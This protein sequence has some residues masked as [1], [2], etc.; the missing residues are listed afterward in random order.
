MSKSR[1]GFS[2]LLLVAFLAFIS[3]GLPDAVLGVAWPSIQGTFDR[4]RADLGYILFA[5]GAGYF[6][7][8]ALAGK[9]IE[10]LGVGRLLAVSTAAVSIGL[11]GYAISSAFPFLMIVAALIGFGSGAVDAGLNVYASEHFSVTVMNWLHAFFGIGAMIGPFIMTGVLA[12]DGSWRI[13]YLIVAGLTLLM[14]IAFVATESRWTDGQHHGET[15]RPAS[16]PVSEVLRQ[17]LLWLQIA[18]FFFMTGIEAGAGAWSYTMLFEKFDLDAGQAGLWAGFYWGTIALGR[19]VLSPLSR[20]LKPAKLIQF[21]TFGLL[22]GALMMTRDQSWLFQAGLLVFGFA[23]A[24]LFPT[25]MS[26]TPSRLGSN[27][28]LHAIG[29]QVSGA[30][31]GGAT[32]PTFAGILAGR[33]TLTAIPWTLAVGAVIVIGLETFLRGRDAG[34]EPMPVTKLPGVT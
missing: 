19:L 13:G 6:S 5:S 8:G 31:L 22:A 11:F 29:F 1:S 26:L 21:G 33:T 10:W 30:V 3:I 18:L 34:D 20:S 2:M 9:A 25:L 24:P 14:A 27:V 7:S 15:V 23:M 32:I 12:T 16:M 28:A 4:P 17:P